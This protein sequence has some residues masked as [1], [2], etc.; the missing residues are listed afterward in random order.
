MY[1]SQMEAEGFRRFTYYLDRPDV[2][3]KFTSVR[4]EADEDRC[5]I[6]LSNGNR[7][8]TGKLPEGRHFAEWSDPFAKP[9]YLFAL[10]AGDLAS[11]QDKFETASGREVHLEVFAAREDKDQLWHAMR[12]LQHAMRWDEERFGLEYDLDIYNIVAVRDFNMGAM[13]NKSLNVFNTSLTLAREDTATDDDYESIEGVI[14]HEYFHNWTGNRVTCRDWFQLTLKE[15][16]TVYRDQEF[17]SDMGSR[18]RK[19]IEDVRILRSYQFPEDSG[20][21][22]HPIRPEKYAAIDNFYTATVYEKGAE[23][24]RMYET[25]LSRDGF[26][27]GM[28]LYFQR[29]DGT[30]VTCDDFRAAMQDANGRDLS[31]FE[32]WYS[33]AGTPLVKAADSWDPEQGIYT[34]TLKQSVPATADDSGTLPMPIPVRLGLLDRATGKELVPDTVLELLEEEHSFELPVAAEEKPVPSLL[35]GFSAPVQLQYDYSDKDLALLAAFDTDSFNRWESMQRLGTKAVLDALAAEDLESFHVEGAF[36]NALRR[37]VQDRETEDLS[38]IAYALILPSESTLIQLA[39][40]P[41][42][43]MRLHAARNRVRKLIAAEAA[44]DL[45]ERYEELTPEEGETYTIDGPNASRRRLRNVLLAYLAAPGT[46]EAAARCGAHFRSA[47]GMTDKEA[48]FSLLC[49]MPDSAEA[50]EAVEVFLAEAKGD[51]NVIDKWFASQAR[52]DVDDLLP[53]VRQ[54]M[55]HPEFTLKN[56]NRL[57]S[58]VSVFIGSPQFHLADGSGYDFALEMIPKVDGLNP[59]VA[60]GM[61]NGAFR[62]WRKLDQDRQ[63]L[64]RERLKALQ[65]M[66]LSK[67]TAEIVSKMQGISEKGTGISYET[68]NPYVA[69]SSDSSEEGGPCTGLSD[70]PN[71]TITDYGSI[72][73]ADAMMKEVLH[74]GLGCGL[75]P[76]QGIATDEGESVDHVVSVVGWGTDKQKGMRLYWIVRN[77]GE[78]WGEMGYGWPREQCSWAVPGSFTAEEKDNQ[79]TGRKLSA[80]SDFLQVE[81]QRSGASQEHRTRMESYKSLRQNIQDLASKADP[82]EGAGMKMYVDTVKNLLNNSM[83]QA[84]RSQFAADETI[85]KNAVSSFGLC[86]DT[87]EGAL[88]HPNAVRAGGHG[89]LYKGLSTLKVKHNDCRGR[90]EAKKIEY[91]MCMDTKENHGQLMNAS[92]D[93]NFSKFYNKAGSGTTG[94]WEETCDTKQ[95]IYKQNPPADIALIHH[96]ADFGSPFGSLGRLGRMAWEDC[97]EDVCLFPCED[98]GE[99]ADCSGEALRGSCIQVGAFRVKLLLAQTCADQLQPEDLGLRIWPGTHAMAWLLLQLERQDQLKQ[100]SVLDVGCGS[101]LVG[102]LAAQGGAGPVTLS[103]RPGRALDLARKNAQL[104]PPAVEVKALAW[105]PEAVDELPD[106]VFDLLLLSEVLY[107]AQPTCVPWSLE[108]ADVEA[109]AQLTK[110]KLSEAG[111]AWVTYGNREAGGA[112]QFAAAAE[113]AGLRCEERALAEVVPPERLEGPQ[114]AALRRVRVFHLQHACYLIEQ[115]DYFSTLVADYEY[116]EK[117][118]FNRTRDFEDTRDRCEKLFKEHGDL[119]AECDNFQDTLDAEACTQQ[120]CRAMEPGAFGFRSRR[121][122]VFG[123]RGMVAT[124]QPL[125]SEAGLRVL[126]QGGTAADACVAAAAALNVTEPCNT[127]LGL[128]L[129]EM[130][131]DAFALFFNAKTKKVECL[132]GCGRSPAALTLEAVKAHPDV[133]GGELPPLSAL[134]VT[135][136]GA[137]SA[138]DAA[139]RRWGALPL[140]PRHPPQKKA[141]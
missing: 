14:G 106:S 36:M 111:H 46:A 99:V 71:A 134:C 126:Q 58:V 44:E 108:E 43:P 137:A 27:K 35:R 33:Q 133:A 125:A 117:L 129:G 32:R 87:L 98:L 139:S 1:C 70:Y 136:P 130:G 93:G 24:I 135:V 17:S 103:D 13:E 96:D 113:R 74:R 101:G 73:G 69:C 59:Q 9:C 16:L 102:L 11:I 51:A 76:S 21:M 105:G 45:R 29:H 83:I 72:S 31:Q 50:K 115:F 66:S 78:F 64:I 85:L 48:A 86:N 55:E 132:Q 49:S 68:S 109:L 119:T 12:S 47:R 22:A 75:K 53:R 81:E 120:T 84:I 122:P 127:G 60:A 94:Q 95:T 121:A 107:V 54:L 131:G 2:M 25:L 63:E 82:G 138:W 140:R 114:S 91:D 97:G 104:N 92:C 57:R 7:I 15:G 56:P 112:E 141:P 34:L 18:A 39:Q 42:D 28:D 90:Q 67:D 65:K 62:T 100:R 6:L 4:I 5:P 41:I 52:A 20:P 88:S 123:K 40:P 79:A 26:R 80:Q 61:A 110:A 89:S 38:L 124:S 30:A 37:T 10:V 77:W 19:R 23:V 128:E 116:A 118:C 3:S 8:A